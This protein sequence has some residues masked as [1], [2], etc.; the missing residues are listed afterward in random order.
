MKGIVLATLLAVGAV[1]ALAQQQPQFTHYGLNGMYLNPAY[2]GIKGQTEVNI[3]GRYQYL[4][5]SNSLGDE[6][7]SPRTGLVSASVPILPLNGGV[8]LVVYYDRAGQSKVTNTAFSYSQHIKLG[9][10]KLGIGIQGIFTFLNKGSYRPNDPNDPFVPESGSDHKF[11]AGAG[12]WYEAPKFYV[13]LSLNNLFRQT[14]TLQ[15]AIRDASGKILGYQNTSQVL[16]ENHAYLTAGYNIEASSSVTVTPMVLVKTVL[17]GNYGDATKYDNQHNYSFEGG[18][19]ATWNDQFWAGLN[20]RYDESISGLVGYGFGPDNRY[21][22]GYAFDFIAFNQAARAF[23]S[24]EIMLS[25]RL[26][27]S[28]PLVRPA[29]RTPRYSY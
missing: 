15:S 23:S 7:G 11:D 16:G 18:I 17:P 25:L 27:K 10:G 6:N 1:P 28:V 2:A 13:G 8:G 22:I 29:I 20:Y 24:H 12:L 14:Y 4:N 3:I 26:P 19:R 21:R 9:R 5:L